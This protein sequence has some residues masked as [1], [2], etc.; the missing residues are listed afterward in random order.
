[1]PRRPLSLDGVYPPIA[2]PFNS[3]GELDLNSLK[4]NVAIWSSTALAGLVALGSNGEYVTLTEKEKLDVVA[5]VAEH[6]PADK[7]LI[8]GTGSESTR[9]TIALT[10]KMAEL[11]AQ[12]ALVITPHYY[13]PRM[14][15]KAL[16][17]HYFSVA[18]AS[19][20]PV[21]IYNMPAFT[22]ID[23]GAET[24][25]KLSEHPNI[26]GMKD[27]TGNVVKMGEVIRF[28][29]PSFKSIA[30]SAS[31]LYPALCVGATGV[32]AAL[33]NVV[34]NAVTELHQAFREGRHNEAK[35][36]QLRLIRPNAAVTS[37]FGVPGLKVAMDLKGFYGGPVRS[38]LLPLDE[39]DRE[40]LRSIFA[41]AG[42]L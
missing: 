12:A 13:R 2:T 18:D 36:L 9:G 20:I 8:A 27:S 29:R 23:L 34:P 42:L 25:I 6:L 41:E 26:A 19:P 21:L 35:E 7:E 31:F 10:R 28:A 38:P 4:K 37:K 3:D 33:A 40:K 30:G 1:M 15:E 11:G 32:V 5:T 16:A 24:L 39:A 14:D 17:N 22:G